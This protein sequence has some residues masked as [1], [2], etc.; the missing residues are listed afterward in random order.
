VERRMEN[1][2]AMSQLSTQLKK[3]YPQSRESLALERGAFNE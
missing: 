2:D 3:R 1:R